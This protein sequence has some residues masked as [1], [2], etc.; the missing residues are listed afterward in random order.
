MATSRVSDLV[1]I[2]ARLSGLSEEALLGPAKHRHVARVRQ[3]V[4]YVAVNQGVHSYPHIGRVMGR[5]H[6]TVFYAADIVPAYMAIDHEYRLLVEAIERAAE[7]ARP[8][9]KTGR[10]DFLIPSEFAAQ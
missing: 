4:M 9:V 7:T 10:P 3:A 1:A 6:K 2:A 8:F 5:D